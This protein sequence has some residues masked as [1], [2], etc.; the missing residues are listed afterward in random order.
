[1]IVFLTHHGARTHCRHLTIDW[2]TKD[3]AENRNN[4]DSNHRRFPMHLT[5][6]GITLHDV[7]DLGPQSWEKHSL[8]GEIVYMVRIVLSTHTIC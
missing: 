5:H 7:Q 1:M 2:V 6:E 3:N 8:E 4:T